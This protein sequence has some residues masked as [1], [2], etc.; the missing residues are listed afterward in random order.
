MVRPDPDTQAIGRLRILARI[1]CIWGFVLLLR[2]VDLQV[3]EH[4][5]YTRLADQQ[6]RR[7]VEVRAPRGEILDR[8]GHTL[9]MSLPVD[10]VCINPLKLADRA[11]AAELLARVLDLDRGELLDRIESAYAAGRGFVWVKR[12]LTPE[13]SASLRSYKLD[14]IEFRTESR[15]FYPKGALA[16]HVLGGVD[17]E[18]NGNAGVELSLNSELQG[19][20]GVMRTVADVKGGVVDSVVFSDPQ[21]GKNLRLTIDE[22]IQYVAER[23]LQNA[24]RQ[25]HCRT[26]SVVVMNPNT[27]E[28]LAL[29]NAWHDHNQYDPNKPPALNENTENRANLAVT[30][31]F[32]PGSVF[33]VIT[34]AAALETTNLRPR[35]IIPCGNGR[36]TLFRRVIRDHDPY[37]ALSMADV[38][39]K[40]SNIGAINIGLKVGNERMLDYIKRFGFGRQTGLS[41]PGESAGL[42]WP[43][44]KWIASS[45]GS[46]AMGHELMTTTVQLAQA[47]SVVANGGLLVKPRLVTERQRPGTAREPEPTVR[48]V[49]VI[50]PETA[51]T[52]RQMMQGVVLNG[53]GRRAQLRGYSSAGKTGSAQ[54]W[55]PLTRVYTHRYNASF[56]GFAPVN[57]P[58]IAIV[59]TLNGASK[60]G[61]A[62]AAPV[63]ERI[64]TA[65][66][67]MLD[68]PKDMPDVEPGPVKDEELSDL[69]IA[70]LSEPAQLEDKPAP[71]PSLISAVAAPA[72]LLAGARGSE[73]PTTVSPGP[74]RD[75]QGAVPAGPTVPD[76][77]GK[78]LRGVLEAAMERGI[79]VEYSGSGLARAQDPPP[80]TVLRSGERVKV[81][82]AR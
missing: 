14:W 31:P 35:T 80:G 69:A 62:V 67:R 9:A 54:I 61:G 64:A 45:I 49:P 23:E 78:S 19:R 4:E 15:R 5:N 75:R 48:T 2:L 38:L 77:T 66:L 39:A 33:K 44:H 3:F 79:T 27:G 63:F 37:D 42:V 76:F 65:A 53:T 47:C 21:P 17:H 29:A 74:S 68:I 40:S 70:E 13:E 34:L 12:K 46:V 43:L 73:S 1:C 56:M 51:N 26:G 10:S 72:G 32:E 16:A 24:V 57:R 28:V 7:R 18:E 60:Y 41:L 58:A 8:N 25:N 52:M 11:L 81:V 59:V 82:F 36:I 55:D 20:P 6:Q 30:A 50:T 22:R 71:A